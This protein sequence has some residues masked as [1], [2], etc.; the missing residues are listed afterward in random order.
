MMESR[1]TRTVS[2]I[3]VSARRIEEVIEEIRAEIGRLEASRPGLSNRAH[4]S[5]PENEDFTREVASAQGEGD[6]MMNL[7]VLRQIEVTLAF[8][9]RLSGEG[10]NLNERVSRLQRQLD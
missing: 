3:E 4:V 2:G 6:P 5:E 1:N 9:S 10:S 8:I 7:F